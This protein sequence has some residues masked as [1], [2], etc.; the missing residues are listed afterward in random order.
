ME[1]YPGS[2]EDPIPGVTGAVIAADVPLPADRVV[3]EPDSSAVAARLAAWARP[4]DVVVTAGAGDVTTLGPKIL[5][6]L[7]ARDG[8][9]APGSTPAEAGSAS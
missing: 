1:V 7:G 2:G 3:F 4:G 8:A 6:L 5:D 9:A